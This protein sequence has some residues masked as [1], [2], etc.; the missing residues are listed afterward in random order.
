MTKREHAAE[1]RQQRP[2]AR[3]EIKRIFVAQNHRVAAKTAA[4]SE[5]W[6][7]TVVNFK[8]YR[9]PIRVLHTSIRTKQRQPF[10]RNQ[11]AIERLDERRASVACEAHSVATFAVAVNL[12]WTIQH[13]N[14]NCYKRKKKQQHSVSRKCKRPKNALVYHTNTHFVETK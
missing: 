4:A 11:R 13:I 8:R 9:G 1:T 3:L 10:V 5:R 6:V 14:N 7:R 12:V 2:G